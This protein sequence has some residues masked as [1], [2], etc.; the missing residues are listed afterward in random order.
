MNPNLTAALSALKHED[1][2][3]VARA[4]AL[5]IVYD[6]TWS[7]QWKHY[8]IIEVER[9]FTFPLLN[10]ETEAASRSWD[11]AGKMDVLALHKPSIRLV[12]L[13]HKTSSEDISPGADYWD[14]LRMD[15]Q[16][17]KYFLAAMHAR[18]G[19]VRSVLY[20]VIGKPA[21]RPCQVP[22]RDAE[23]FKIVLDA[24]GNRIMAAN[25]KKPR[26]TPDVERGWALQSRLE[27][28][29]EF[30]SRLLVVLRGNP[31]AYFAQQEIPRLD[32]D[33]LEYMGDQWAVG[34]QLLYFR[35]RKLWSR[36]P[37]ACKLMGTCEMF[38]LCCGRASVDGVR[39]RKRDR[40]HAELSI[41]SSDHGA[42]GGN[43]ELLT[44]SRTTCFN[45]CRRLHFLRYEEGI[46]KTGDVNENLSFGT[47]VHKGLEA[48][49]NSIKEHQQ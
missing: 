26:E 49:F 17:S 44:N 2:Y 42:T 31:H 5:L 43:R 35:N 14:Q 1:P 21:Q 41:Q 39:Y 16:C 27:T 13:E 22:L 34:Q 3:A 28:P 40:I 36:N 20:D 19:E 15:T 37:K 8:H 33:I 18:L 47:L 12:V 11:E 9:E 29:E 6:Q 25:G 10:P 32:S 23:G 24:G 46:E 45:R 48:Y 38:N 4:R 7:E 30:E